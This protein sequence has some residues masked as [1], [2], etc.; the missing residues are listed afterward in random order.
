LEAVVQEL[1]EYQK[2]M[3]D[4]VS[5]LKGYFLEDRYA[6]KAYA[7]FGRWLRRIQIELPF[8]LDK[9]IE[10]Q[11]EARLSHEELMDVLQLDILIRGQSR[12]QPDAPELWLALE[13][14]A[15][16]DRDD[17]E[18][19]ERRAALLRKAGYAAI[20][21]VAGGGVTKGATEAL[22]DKP[23]VLILDGRSQ[24]WEEALASL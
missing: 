24:G 15:V 19:A 21:G 1:A 12:H 11:L 10:G 17:V 2:R 20:P 13:V 7:Y 4:D 6:S 9:T 3:G 14:S 8:S 22:Q 5:K 18:R 16:I 23:I